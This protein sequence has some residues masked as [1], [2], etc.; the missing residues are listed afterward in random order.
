MQQLAIIIRKDGAVPFDDGLHPDH[1]TAMLGHLA[2][3]G[4]TVQ[5]AEDGSV[6]LAN[7]TP[8]RHAELESAYHAKLA[9]DA[10]DEA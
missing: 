10:P 4:H 2:Q 6:T 7:F 1:K 3:L 9:A 8:E 5:V